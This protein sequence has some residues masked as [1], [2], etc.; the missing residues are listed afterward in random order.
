MSSPDEKLVAFLP[1]L[2][3]SSSVSVGKVNYVPFEIGVTDQDET[4]KGLASSLTK[5]LSSYVSFLD[6]SV[7]ACTVVIKAERNPLWNLEKGDFEEVQWATSLLFLAASAHND[8]FEQLPNYVNRAMFDLYWQRFTEP[9]DFVTLTARRRDGELL[10]GGYRHGQVK[11]T[12]PIQAESS[13]LVSP[14][15][16]LLRAVDAAQAESSDVTRRLRAALS[17]FSACEY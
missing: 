5:I 3:L 6:R 2:K 13:R 8:Y 11:F 9:V 16:G 14:D 12:V 10:I 4:L 1:W 15:T 17:F 7:R